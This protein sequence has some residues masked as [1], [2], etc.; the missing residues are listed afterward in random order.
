MSAVI[1][2][3]KYHE[4]LD[5]LQ[6]AAQSKLAPGAGAVFA[7]QLRKKMMSTYLL[8]IGKVASVMYP[9]NVSEIVKHYD[10]SQCARFMSRVG[11]LVV[12]SEQGVES[13]FW[14]P[15]DV[16]DP[17]FKE[18][19]RQMKQFVE[20]GRITTLFNPNGPYQHYK[21]ITTGEGSD[22]QWQHFFIQPNYLRHRYAGLDREISFDDFHK[23]ADRVN[24]L[25]KLT[26]EVDLATVMWVEQ[27]FQARTLEHLE[28]SEATIKAFADLLANL[29]VAQS[30]VGYTS[31]ND[32][33]KETMLV[34]RIWIFAM[35]HRALAALRG[36]LV[37]KLLA[38]AA[39]LMK[40]PNRTKAHELGLV[41]FWKEQSSSL[42]YRRTTAP[43]SSGQLERTANFL[44]ENNWLPSFKQ[45]E[46]AEVDV[47]ALWQAPSRWTWIEGQQVSAQADF[48]E[49]AARKGVDV[50]QVKAP[51]TMD[52][53]YFYNEVLKHVDALGVDMTDLSWKPAL[54]NTMVDL[55]AKPI[56]K[57]DSEERRAPF[58]PWTYNQ[59]FRA[60]ELISDKSVIQN[61]RVILPVLSI[62]SSSVIGYHGRNPEAEAL[63][64]LFHGIR[65]PHAPRPALFADAVKSELYEYRRAIEDYSASTQ[66]PRAE[67]QQSIGLTF[68]P[69]H[70]NQTGSVNITLHARL[71]DAGKVLFGARD[72]RFV[73]DGTGYKIKPTVD[74]DKAIR[75]R[76]AVDAPA[77]AEAPA[78][79]A[80]VSLLV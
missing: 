32:Y 12:E 58:V 64:F 66:I 53:G 16:T 10:C 30:L 38:E 34:N 2:S 50:E 65:M 49:F 6:I 51:I 46:A 70:P 8:V 27:L 15:D 19:V 20:G 72:I 73:V 14:N 3:L 77:P 31:A 9:D 75:D 13:V 45:R 63:M 54:L 55:T 25:I 47:P 76:L 67:G 79:D 61:G 37:G 39:K 69:R 52:I 24:S 7:T 42:H 4:S 68:G 28:H 23:T 41:S 35:K 18:V 40:N 78:P 29:S 17:F 62:T 57:W 43:A 21:N 44:Q 22:T 1:D 59:N 80:S 56:F 71:N 48:A 26:K 11:H 60:G 33:V 74:E 5:Q 36:S